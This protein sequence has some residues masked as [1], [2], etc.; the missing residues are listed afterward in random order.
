MALQPFAQETIP[1][2][3]T[4]YLKKSKSQKTAAR[5]L[6][7]TGGALMLI[8]AL[9]LVDDVIGIV[10]PDDKQN[11]ALADALGYTG[12][13]AVIGSI[14]LFI[15]SGKNKRKAMSLSFNRQKMPLLQKSS[16]AYQAIPSMKLTIHF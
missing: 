9:V 4:D 15:A 8:S 16:W 10:E 6:L 12:A 2:I 13:A 7:G 1:A 3:N 14:P 5:I 11:L